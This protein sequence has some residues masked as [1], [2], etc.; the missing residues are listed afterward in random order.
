MQATVNRSRRRHSSET[1]HP[2]ARFFFRRILIPGL[3]GVLATVALL[4]AAAAVRPQPALASPSPLLAVQ[5]AELALPSGAA[6]DFFGWSVAISGDTAVV[7][8]PHR[9]VGPDVGQGAVYV[10]TR[11]GDSWT[12]QAELVSS[13]GA[14]N[15]GFGWS[16]AVSGDTVV[17]GAPFHSVG[18]NSSQ[19][20]AYV[21]TD[22][23]T[24][25]TQQAELTATDGAASDKFGAAVA[26]SGDTVLV[27]AA[28]HATSGDSGRGAAYVFTG[29]GA[30]W[31]QQAELTAGDG[32]PYDNF[33]YSVALDGQTAVV[34]AA[35]HA[36]GANNGQGAAYV[37]TGS[38][39]SWTQQAELTASDGAPY[40]NF[41]RSLAVSGDTVLV[42]AANHAT[43]GDANQGAAYVFTGS[44]ASWTQQ[45]E[46]T[47]SDGASNDYFGWSVAL[48]GDSAVVGAYQHTAND[49]LYDGAAYLFARSGASWTQQQELTASDGNN[50]DNFGD[51]VA[52]S[53][54]TAVVGAPCHAVG[55]N[56]DQGAAYVFAGEPT[57]S[58]LD[59]TSG[60]A[61]G[62]T[63]VTISG[64]GFT[65][66]TAVEFGSTPAATFDV[67]NDGTITATSPAG[68][69]TVDVTVTAPQ[70]TTSA[71]CT[72]DQFSYE[73][74]SPTPTPTPTPSPT[75]APTTSVS[76]LPAHWVNHAVTLRFV[77]TAATGGVPV[78]YTEYRLNAG[79]WVKG[80]T[81][82]IDQ[83]GATTVSYRS[84]DSNG[85][86]EAVQSCIVRID[87]TPPVLR[88]NPEL[89]IAKR[90]A[91]A[92]I[93]YWVTDNIS[94]SCTVRA[95][96][97][98]YGRAKTQV[99]A[100][101][102]RRCGRWFVASFRFTLPSGRYALHLVA[103]DGAGNC[104][105]AEAAV[106]LH[107]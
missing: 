93:S 67:S 39:A 103:T 61:S 33:G 56:G 64:S 22:S 65:G 7:S 18:G 70:G 80:T 27:G 49:N 43:S 79:T 21:F 42:G 73:A 83:Q 97:T 2:S 105:R 71:T 85:N 11:S 9:A 48:D 88:M 58:S 51:A 62:G 15:D 57:V 34:A 20:A 16:V 26:I 37:F 10:F 69:G 95:I 53:G 46:L 25:W 14:S 63:S 38:G 78:A 102:L 52:L 40:D 92:Q 1:G 82:T 90:G 89:L 74:A 47:A 98:Q 6:T 107:R 55:S 24:G 31:T 35:N 60:P 106:S 76:G 66:A 84:A 87:T 41:G 30:S 17:V 94:T 101:G 8:A 72:A 59:P 68:S 12:Q 50:N 86:L 54:E 45:A 4:V 13:D 75:T 28:D 29:S 91:L 96:V 44:G 100:L 81:V 19:G 3:L 23:G 32:A 5:Q 104:G 99:Y 77:A 36:V